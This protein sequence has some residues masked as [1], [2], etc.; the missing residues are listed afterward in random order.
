MEEPGDAR[1]P[2][3]HCAWRS[4]GFFLLPL[5][6]YLEERRRARIV[7]RGLGDLDLDDVFASRKVEHHVGQDLLHDR[8]ETTCAGAAL[9]RFLRH[10]AKGALVEA[11]FHFFELEEL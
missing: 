2:A 11:E 9:E 1:P 8:A 4:S 5:R 6:R 10:G 7:H 3:L